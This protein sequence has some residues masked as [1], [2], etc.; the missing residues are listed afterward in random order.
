LPNEDRNNRQWKYRPG[1]QVA[2]MRT[3]DLLSKSNVATRL[4]AQDLSRARAFYAEKLGL[5]PIEERPGGLR[6]KCGSGYFSLFESS[7]VSSGDH[8]QMAWEVDDLAGVVAELR[9]R[10]VV[11]E[12]VDLPDLKT[13][14]GI[15]Q[16]VGNYASAGGVGERAAWFRDSEGNLLGIGQP[17]A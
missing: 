15:A 16:V 17:I 5:E 14:D 4:P 8:T 9:L 2:D 7:G 11:F 10:G 6:Y 13:V 12:D 1:A 3:Q